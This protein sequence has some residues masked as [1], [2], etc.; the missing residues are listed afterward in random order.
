MSPKMQMR[1]SCF[2]PGHHICT[3][4]GWDAA[5][6]PW[7]AAA[8]QRNNYG[9]EYRSEYFEEGCIVHKTGAIYTFELSLLKQ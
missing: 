3:C 2:N 5:N 8:F 9:S 1:C 6:T 4:A 7:Q